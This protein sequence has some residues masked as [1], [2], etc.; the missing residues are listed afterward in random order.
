MQNTISET[1]VLDIPLLFEAKLT[2]MATE[3]WVVSCDCSLQ[4]ARLQKR[5]NLTLSQAEARIN[6]QI[7]LSEK[8]AAADVVLNNNQDVAYLYAQIDKAIKPA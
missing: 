5:N 3:I 2:E 6:S 4:I 1:V 8:M 7:P